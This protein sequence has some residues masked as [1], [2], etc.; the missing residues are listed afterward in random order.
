MVTGIPLMMI[1]TGVQQEHHQLLPSQSHPNSF[2]TH[3]NKQKI[4]SL[5][6]FLSSLIHTETSQ[7]N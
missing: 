5:G 7:T 6:T 4:L 1:L 2:F 3:K